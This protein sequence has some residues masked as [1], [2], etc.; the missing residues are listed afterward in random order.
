MD[1]KLDLIKSSS[2][3]LLLSLLAEREMY[4]YQ[5][6]KELE[7][8]S[9]G[10]FKFKEGTLYPALHRLERSGLI[11]GEWRMLPNG[12]QRRYY[13]ITEK[14]LVK[15]GEERVQWQ[16]FFTAVRMILEPEAPQA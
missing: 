6:V 16:N 2:T 8:R 1:T 9:Q 3:S 11:R 7:A 10:Y 12:R 4:G 5:I 15:L 13:S 14:G